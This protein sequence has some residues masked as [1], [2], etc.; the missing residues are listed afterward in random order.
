MPEPSAGR[1]AAIRPGLPSPSGPSGGAGWRG[2]CCRRGQ[3]VVPARCSATHWRIVQGPRLASPAA[4]AVLIRPDATAA[5]STARSPAGRTGPPR[6]DPLRADTGR[7]D[8][9]RTGSA[10]PTVSGVQWAGCPGRPRGA[11]G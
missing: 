6:T 10:W 9:D 5:A 7:A 1:P 2:Q 11:G 3:P 8:T 4:C